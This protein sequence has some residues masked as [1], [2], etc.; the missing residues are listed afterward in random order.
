MSNWQIEGQ[1]FETCNCD[2]ICPCITSNL[3]AVPTEGDC[4][5]AIT[6]KVDSGEKDGV[7]LGGVSFIVLLHTPG[8]MGEGDMTVGLIVDDSATD[9]QV[10]AIAV[11]ASGQDGGPMAALA[12]LV[13]KNAG[14]ERCAIQIE[15]DGSSYSVKV[16]N[17]VDQGG[18]GVMSA[19]DP[20]VPMYLEN[21]AHPAN[22][23]LALAKATH[24]KFHAFG[25][26]WED[27][28]GTR[29]GHFAPFN[30]AA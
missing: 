7:Q 26:D 23:R 29:N 12:P 27:A 21:T 4:K 22:A 6:M 20:D 25:I 16:G 30:W 3:A 15:S 24:N 14:I 1:Y 8:A 10:D 28:S 13:T 11:I 2:F 19:A 5:A 9:E 17:L 18:V